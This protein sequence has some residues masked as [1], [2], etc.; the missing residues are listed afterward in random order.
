MQQHSEEMLSAP[1]LELLVRSLAPLLFPG[2]FPLLYLLVLMWKAAAGLRFSRMRLPDRATPELARIRH[3]PLCS[4]GRPGR[5]P[6]SKA[7]P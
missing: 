3:L 1:P 7:T 6:E 4:W 2:P 5:L